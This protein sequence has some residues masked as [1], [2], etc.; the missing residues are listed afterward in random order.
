M[1]HKSEIQNNPLSHEKDQGRI[2]DGLWKRPIRGATPPTQ[3]GTTGASNARA[4]ASAQIGMEMEMFAYDAHTLVPLGLP[5]AAFHPSELLRRMA[6]LVEGS[7]LKVDPSTGVVVGLSLHSGANFSLEPGGQVEFSSAPRQTT[8]ALVEDVYLGLSAL[9]QAAGEEVV[10]LSHG[11]NPIAPENM[12]LLV[13]KERYQILRRYFLS[14]PGGRGA[15]MMGH[16]CT[17]QPNIDIVGDDSDWED[18]VRLTFALTPIVKALT[19]NSLYFAGQRSRYVS[20]RQ[21]IWECTDPTRSGIP[22]GIVHSRDVACHYAQWARDAHVFL[23]RGLPVEEQPLFG[24]STF[25]KFLRDG[26]KGVMPTL[27]DWELHLATL[28]PEL[29]LRGFLEIRCLDAQPFEHLL[30]GVMLWKGLLLDPVAR[31]EAW[32]L[33]STQALTQRTELTIGRELLNLSTQALRRMGD[34]L[35]VVTLEAAAARW[36]LANTNTPVAE[37]AQEFVQKNATSSPAQ[38]FVSSLHNAGVRWDNSR[39]RPG[40]GRSKR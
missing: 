31:A 7:K 38:S 33:L 39:G 6:D 19:K 12:P 40:W 11:T 27:Q 10:F 5:G 28:F 34:E 8:A 14:E 29:R 25:E 37:A 30:A 32:S 23:V 16:T 15:D 21:R 26:Y 1:A 36:L 3:S 20:E 22:E 13:P 35:G 4:M 18:A 9:Q 17:V 2:C 24:E